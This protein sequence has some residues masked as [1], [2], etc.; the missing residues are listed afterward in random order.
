[1]LEPLKQILA[2]VREQK[3]LVLCLT[4]H[5]TMDLMANALL[6]LGAAP[7]MSEDQRE[8]NELIQ[9]SH[10]LYLNI[11]TLEPAFMERAVHA[12]T[13]AKQLKKPIIL[14]PVGAGATTIR[15]KA[16]LTLLPFTNIVRGNASEIISLNQ[17]VNAT[18]G[19]EATH[20]VMDA[21]NDASHLAKTHQ[22]TVVVSG[23]KD[24]VTNGYDE[25]FLPFGSSLMP[26]VT[27]MG[28]TLTAVI[29]AFH[30]I[31]PTS[32]IAAREATRYFGLC[33]Q[34]AAMKTSSPGHFRTLFLDELY[35]CNLDA[36]ASVS[37]VA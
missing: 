16:S 31:E 5:V 27:G 6:C 36:M 25:I 26:F 13:L 33:G 23:P 10:A 20:A 11:G 21:Q 2:L 19:V 3:P 9:I 14:D 29:A 17:S 8:L 7:I 18:L 4:N 1:M 28:C 34:V 22:N 24:Y 32:F 35:Q 30:A 15:T 37:H 12:A